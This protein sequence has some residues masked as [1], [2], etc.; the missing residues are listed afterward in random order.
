MIE[1]FTNRFSFLKV[2]D[3]FYETFK[4]IRTFLTL[5]Y[6]RLTRTYSNKVLF[7]P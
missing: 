1:D 7:V 6:L 5:F 4:W 3:Q 2:F